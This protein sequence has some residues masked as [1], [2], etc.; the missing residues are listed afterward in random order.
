MNFNSSA[1][2]DLLLEDNNLNQY[3][4]K[5]NGFF[6]IMD[7][8]MIVANMDI[9]GLSNDQD[10]SN[11]NNSYPQNYYS[12]TYYSDLNT[13]YKNESSNAVAAFNKNIKMALVSKIDGTKIADI[14]ERS[15]KDYWYYSYNKWNNYGGYWEYSYSDPGVLIQYYTEVPYLRFGDQSEVSMETYFSTGFTTFKTN[16]ENYLKAFER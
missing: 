12:S 6:Q 11:P 7:N 8:F 1:K 2:I 4:G 3:L 16:V 10:A 15:E 14:I 5:A 13:Y 9:E